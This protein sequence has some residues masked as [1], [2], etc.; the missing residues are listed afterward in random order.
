MMIKQKD[1][2]YCKTF[3]NGRFSLWNAKYNFFLFKIKGTLEVPAVEEIFATYVWPKTTENPHFCENKMDTNFDIVFWSF[4]G[5]TF[6]KIIQS[7]QMFSSEQIIL[8]PHW[9][10]VNKHL[11]GAGRGGRCILLLQNLQHKIV[12]WLNFWT[13]IDG[14]YES[15]YPNNNDRNS[16]KTWRSLWLLCIFCSNGK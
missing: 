15:F 2:K 1:N 16:Q 7:V 11:I 10:N 8:F 14:N 4:F 5:S 12:N 9:G 3:W 6:P 13:Q